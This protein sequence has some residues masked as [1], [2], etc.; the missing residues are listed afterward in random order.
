MGGLWPDKNQSNSI[1]PGGTFDIYVQV[2]AP[3]VTLRGIDGPAVAIPPGQGAGIECQVYYGE[4]AF[5][6]GSWTNIQTQAMSY[7]KDIGNND[8]YK[9]TLSTLPA[10]LYE[11]TARCA[12][13]GTNNWVWVSDGTDNGKLIVGAD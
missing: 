6:G 2:Y 1:L 4:V 11:Y 10:G 12:A 8:E 9:V 3:G 7:N 5:F 13:T